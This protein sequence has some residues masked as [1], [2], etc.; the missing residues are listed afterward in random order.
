MNVGTV[1]QEQP[2]PAPSHPGLSS[3]VKTSPR[4]SERQAGFPFLRIRNGK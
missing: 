1:T 2:H 3:T 4:L